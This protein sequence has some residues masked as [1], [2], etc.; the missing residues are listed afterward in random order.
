MSIICKRTSKD[1]D[2]LCEL[3]RKRDSKLER[4]KMIAETVEEMNQLNVFIDSA[5][6]VQ[7]V[8]EESMGVKTS[9]MEIK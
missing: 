7:K 5:R 3:V 8:L 4:Q 6:S 9:Q 2:F 1:N